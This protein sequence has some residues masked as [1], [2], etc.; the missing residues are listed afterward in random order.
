[1][2]RRRRLGIRRRRSAGFAFVE[3]VRFQEIERKC[4]HS[5]D[6][7]R[8]ASPALWAHVKERNKW[9]LIPIREAPPCGRGA[10]QKALEDRR[11]PR[12]GLDSG[13]QA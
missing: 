6:R 1:M 4:L 5:H 12:S 9:R 3:R 2:R 11:A 8:S 13:F 10:S 7:E